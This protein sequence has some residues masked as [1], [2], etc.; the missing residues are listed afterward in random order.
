MSSSSSSSGTEGQ[1]GDETSLAQGPN[2]ATVASDDERRKTIHG[3]VREGQ[4]DRAISLDNSSDGVE[5]GGCTGD[6]DV[7]IHLNMSGPSTS[8]A[9]IKG[10]NK[11]Q[12]GLSWTSSRVLWS[13]GGLVDLQGLVYAWVFNSTGAYRLPPPEELPSCRCVD[14]HGE[15]TDDIARCGIA[16]SDAAVVYFGLGRIRRLVF[17]WPLTRI[18]KSL[19]EE[20]KEYVVAGFDVHRRT[21]CKD[22]EARI[23]EVMKMMG[24]PAEAITFGWYLT[25]GTSILWLIPAALMTIICWGTVFQHS[26]KFVVFLFFW[27]FGMCARIFFL[28]Y[29]PYMPLGLRMEPSKEV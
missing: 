28:L 7:V 14:P 20:Y 17:I 8:L 26:N 15:A 11:L 2:Q 18:I 5:V 25:Y 4:L 1:S 13:G 19:V 22:K 27:L 16:L 21:N 23:N 29:F 6:W 10:V 12:R 9:D 3:E 24:M